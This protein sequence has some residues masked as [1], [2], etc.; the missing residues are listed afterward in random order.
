MMH[1][2]EVESIIDRRHD[3]AHVV[4]GE[5]VGI[6]PHPNA[7]KLRIASVV[8]RA[9]GAPQE[10]VCGA[11]NIAVGQKVAVA[12][13]GA[14]L[15][16]GMTIESRPIRGVISNGMICA[17]D[18]LGLGS[19]HEGVMVLDS[20]ARV[21]SAFA[22]A[23]GFDECVLDIA[24]PAN[25]ADLMSM[26]GLAREIGAILGL[27]ARLPS[28]KKLASRAPSPL[29]AVIAEPKLCALYTSQVIRGVTVGPSP[30]W[31]Q[32]R[33]RAAGVRP[34]NAV[35]DV[36]NYVMLEYGQPLHAFDAQTLSGSTITV[37]RARAGETMVTLDGHRRQLDTAMI[38]VADEEGPIA[39]AGVM[40][41]QQTEVS[42]KTVDVVLEA[43]LFHPVAI[44][45][46]S[47]KLG[48]LSEA[49]KR[50][51]KGLWATGAIEA[52]QAAAAMLVDLCGGR[53]ET[54]M[55]IAGKPK[56]RNVKISVRP[57]YIVERLGMVVSTPT[58]KSAAMRL[59]F[60][61]SGSS[62]WTVTVPVWR[63]DVTAREDVV[64]EIG[65]MVGYDHIP[66]V[67]PQT[68]SLPSP[69]G[70]MQVLTDDVRRLLYGFG[71]TETL[72]HA[73]YES[74]SL[75]SQQHF[76]IAN[77][78]DA[79]QAVLRR[80]LV[81]NVTKQLV[82]AADEGRDVQLF[83]IG[84]VFTPEAK[85]GL[86]NQQ[87]VKLA[88]GMTYRAASQGRTIRSLAEELARSLGVPYR[89]LN[90][91]LTGGEIKGRLAVVYEF[92][93]SEVLC[94]RR[95]VPYVPQ[96]PF[97]SIRRDISVYV[98]AQFRYD[99][100]LEAIY[101]ALGA[102]SSLL[103]PGHGAS[104]YSDGKQRSFKYSFVFQASDRTLTKDEVDAIEE[105]IKQALRSLGATLR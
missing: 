82:Q 89:D 42:D 52:S 71:S 63:L 44:R 3:F 57:N 34:L 59:G 105:K 19:S 104:Y 45:S 1:G 80:S 84:R 66:S 92:D 5:I 100:S 47:R 60:R 86:I 77:P 88:I 46:T 24:V 26:R 43:A 41:G 85:G 73:Y 68:V 15:P 101:T 56:D 20:H 49:S 61:V 14:Q 10:I 99:A 39:L 91:E 103:Q 28:V 29:K 50:F 7:D 38:V 75:S 98:G 76:R 32:R 79:T 55:R 53:I 58:M 23:M 54:A 36:T 16:N 17:E 31:M 22:E 25:R 13:L 35:V 6:Q 48:L 2:L 97:P 12:L 4:V 72:S 18:E 94:L 8:V 37:R 64:D 51:E 93:M 78:L 62:T 70:A 87:P 74:S 30:E 102:D 67:I 11:P 27:S 9:K 33:L 96:S 21:G 65:R 69:V 95:H 90:I 81:P 83:E 40:G